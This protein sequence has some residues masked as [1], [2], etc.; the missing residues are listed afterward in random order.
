MP[1][2]TAEDKC[3]VDLAPNHR[4]N[5][6]AGATGR[7]SGGCLRTGADDGVRVERDQAVNR[8]L[9]AGLFD[10]SDCRI[11][12]T[13]QNLVVG[14][15]AW[16]NPDL[17]LPELLVRG[18][19]IEDCQVTLTPLRMLARVVLQIFVGIDYSTCH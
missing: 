9:S 4:F 8:R 10:Q 18:Q 2:G 12:V 11:T 1:G 16:S 14:G 5:G 15:R 13:A 7:Q 19:P 3:L 6:A 17:P